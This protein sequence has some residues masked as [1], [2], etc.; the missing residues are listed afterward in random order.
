MQT[1]KNVKKVQINVKKIQIQSENVHG[2]KSV[3][4]IN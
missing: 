4:L 1:G 2:L 3:L